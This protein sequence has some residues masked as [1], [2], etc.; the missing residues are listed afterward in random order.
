[1]ITYLT[2]PARVLWIAGWSPDGTQIAYVSDVNGNFDLYTFNL[3]TLDYR[4]LTDDPA[5]EVEVHWLPGRDALIYGPAAGDRIPEEPPW[6][7]GTLYMLDLQD[8]N[9]SLVGEGSY[10]VISVD[11]EGRRIAFEGPSQHTG[12]DLCM[13]DLETLEEDCELLGEHWSE[14]SSFWAT[15]WSADGTKLAF[16]AGV[17]DTLCAKTNILDL[18]TG[19][20]TTFD[21]GCYGGLTPPLWSRD[22]R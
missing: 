15:A 18:Q 9:R 21:E 1:V 17:P 7:V 22:R 13:L 10:S 14:I 12:Q 8:G 5:L 16:R 20:L 2:A 4:Q 3:E 11:P 19:E 6:A